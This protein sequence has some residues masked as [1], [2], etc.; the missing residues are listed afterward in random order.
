MAHR[1]DLM[2]LGARPMAF[3][4]F[5][6]RKRQFENKYMMLI[7]SVVQEIAQHRER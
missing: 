5:V 7:K 4:S 6:E 1:S 3:H 2:E